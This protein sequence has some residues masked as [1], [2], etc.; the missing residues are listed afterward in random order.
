VA[1]RRLAKLVQIGAA[2]SSTPQLGGG[3]ELRFKP[4]VLQLPSGSIEVE[5]QSLVTALQSQLQD[6]E[7]LRQAVQGLGYSEQVAQS[8]FGFASS[9]V[10]NLS[11]DRLDAHPI[12]PQDAWLRMNESL[13]KLAAAGRGQE[14]PVTLI[15]GAGRGQIADLRLSG[16]G[17]GN[18]QVLR[19]QF[20]LLIELMGTPATGPELKIRVADAA[21]GGAS[22]P[23]GL[24]LENGIPA[25]VDLCLSQRFEGLFRRAHANYLAGVARGEAD[26]GGRNIAAYCVEDEPLM[27]RGGAAGEADA[28]HEGEG[29]FLAGFFEGDAEVAVVLEIKAVEFRELAGVVGNRAGG[30]VGKLLGDAAAEM[31]RGD[32]DAFVRAEGLVG[33]VGAHGFRAANLRENAMSRNAILTG[34]KAKTADRLGRSAVSGKLKEL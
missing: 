19:A 17:T 20:S 16:G 27:G 12:G 18:T 31:V 22:T 28:E 29:F 2:W 4:R 1:H 30:G 11:F 25:R 9:G 6:A 21:A 3:T 33:G 13:D 34:R 26:G 23:Q 7:A 8:H 10:L 24:V 32:L 15:L 14:H 5:L